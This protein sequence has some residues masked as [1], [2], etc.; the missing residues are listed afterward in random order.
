MLSLVAAG[1]LSVPITAVV[2][3]AITPL[4]WKLEPIT[5][6]ELA[7]HSGPSDWLIVALYAVFVIVLFLAILRLSRGRGTPSGPGPKLP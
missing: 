5:G 7:G 3:I 6:M 4:L 2:S 1:I